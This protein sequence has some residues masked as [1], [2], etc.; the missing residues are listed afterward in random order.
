VLGRPPHGQ[1]PLGL[2]VD[3]GFFAQLSLA[4]RGRDSPTSTK[5]PGFADID[6]AAG[7]DLAVPS[8]PIRL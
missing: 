8:P 5:P 4:G 6:E 3:A 2:P 7:D 1:E